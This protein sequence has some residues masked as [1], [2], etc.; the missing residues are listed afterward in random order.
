MQNLLHKR[1]LGACH[2]LLWDCRV[3]SLSSAFKFQPIY[4]DDL[5]HKEGR[6][7][8]LDAG[9][10]TRLPP[11]S[12]YWTKPASTTLDSL[13]K[14]VQTCSITMQTIQLSRYVWIR[15]WINQRVCAERSCTIWG[16]RE[17]CGSPLSHHLLF[18]PRVVERLLWSQMAPL[19]LLPHQVAHPGYIHFHKHTIY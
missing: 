5:C 15:R 19:L 4:N 13:Q 2:A 8:N 1:H 11:A 6:R 14:S 9:A 3:G 16:L 12:L 7:L 10:S 17:H 18:L